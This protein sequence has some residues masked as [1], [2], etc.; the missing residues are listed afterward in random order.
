MAARFIDRLG[1]G[2]RGAPRDAL[3]V[4]LTPPTLRGASFGLRQSLDTVGA[5]L[6]PLVAIAL[7]WLTADSFTLVFW[8]AVVPAFI[9]VAVIVFTVKEPPQKDRWPI[10]TLADFSRIGALGRAFWLVVGVATIFAF[11]RFS[12][13]FLVLRAESVGLP[14][15]L[16]PAVLVVMNIAYSLSAFPVGVLSDRVDRM[17]M[18]VVGLS[19]LVVADLILASAAGVVAL[20]IGVSLWG[21]HMGFTQGLLSALVAYTAPGDRR[22]TAFGWFNL[23]S[24]LGQFGASLVAGAL[25]DAIGPGSTFLAGAALAVLVLIAS[26]AARPALSRLSDGEQ[27]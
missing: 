3:V 12:E 26:L 5:F 21:L 13:A 20:A 19:V 10:S 23:L 1:K 24:G 6:G 4:D 16:I 11:A 9:S 7:M 14:V 8:V 25:W 27:R 22:G 15:M 18:L 17:T 2:I